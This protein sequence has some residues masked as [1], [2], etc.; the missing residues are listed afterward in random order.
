[1]DCAMSEIENSCYLIYL[2][3]KK[4]FVT[5]LNMA[6]CKSRHWNSALKLELELELILQTPLLPVP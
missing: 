6:I 5:E 2:L 4:R 1:M 3:K